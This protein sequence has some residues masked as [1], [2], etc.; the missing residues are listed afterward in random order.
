MKKI[1][2][3][4]ETI[5]FIAI[6]MLSFSVAMI[7]TASF[8][9]SMLVAPAYNLSQKVTFLTLGQCE[10]IIQ[11][12]LFFVL[13]I[14][15]KKVKIIYFSSFL[16]CILYGALLDLWRVIIPVF[17]PA[18]TPQGSMSMPIRIIFFAI[19]M[20]LTAL[21]VALFY[22][23]YLYPQV[24]D[25]FVKSISAKFGIDRTKLKRIFD[26]G[27]LL[28]ACTMTLIFFQRF[29][30]VGIVTLIMTIFNG[31]LIGF[32]GRQLD[33]HFEFTPYFKKLAG[34]FEL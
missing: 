30:G 28:V 23:T 16:T 4:C 9:V 24:Y 29:I 12:L 18:I 22:R 14:I 3:H 19:G 31:I 26:A 27:C 34:Y 32:V 10:Y 20:L 2:L 1:R 7:T 11:G 15:M 33:E 21:S 5:Y 13:C 17:N 8:G 25:F 6:L